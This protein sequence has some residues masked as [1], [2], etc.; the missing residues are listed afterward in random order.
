MSF[1]ELER[2]GGVLRITLNRPEVLNAFNAD[3]ARQMQEALAAA[4]TDQTVRAL[5]LTGAGRAFCAGQDLASVPLDG[6]VQPDL[7]AIVRRQYNPT[8][9]ALVAMPKPVVCAVNGVAAGAGANLA[10]ACDIVIAS[11][12]ASFVQSFAKIGLV[13]DSGGTYLLPRLVG[14]A[15]AA[16]LALLG[17]A[18]T[19]QQAM[20]WGL[21]WNV[22]EPERLMPEAL[23]LAHRLARA[24]TKG[25]ALTKRALAASW[26]NDLDTQLELEASLQEEAGRT[27]D[28]LEGIRAFKEKREA[29]F[30]GE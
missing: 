6:A 21:V 29:D 1:I 15:R 20:E 12:R 11:A 10:L 9:V 2:D 19:A 22:C 5:L 13:P 23:A 18:L 25:L 8:I 4:K 7:G 17:E 14:R 26:A 27:R 30:I 28:F 24:P 16:G 3:M